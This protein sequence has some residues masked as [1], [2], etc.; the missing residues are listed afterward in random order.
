M[1]FGILDVYHHQN[2]DVMD[3]PFDHVLEILRIFKY[4]SS[5][6]KSNEIHG[7]LIFPLFYFS[8]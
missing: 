3:V 8:Q 4:T 7:N 5:L 2:D 6:E 1:K